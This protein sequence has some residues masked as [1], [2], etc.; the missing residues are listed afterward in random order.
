MGDKWLLSD[1]DCCFADQQNSKIPPMA[2]QIESVQKWKFD[3]FFNFRLQDLDNSFVADLYERLKDMGINVFQPDVMSESGEQIS[4]EIL[5]A[6][7]E[8]RIAITICSK[9]Y[10]SSPRCLEELTKIMECVDNKGLE[11]FFVFYKVEPSDD[12]RPTG[13]F[14]AD[15][16]GSDLEKVQRWQDALRKAADMAGLK[17]YFSGAEL[18]HWNNGKCIE[19]ISN[20]I[21]QVPR[22]AKY[23]VGIKS[24]VEE[25]KSLLKI[26]FGGVYFIGVWGRGGVGKTAV[27]REI[28]DEISCQFE[29]SCFLN[30]R[31]FLENLGPEGP[32]LLQQK[33]LVKILKEHPLN[34]AS[35]NKEVDI[36]QILRFKKVLIVLDDVYNSHQLEYLAGQH[37]WFGDGS[38]IITTT[39]NCDLLSK[40][41]EFYCVPELTNH[42]A[43]ELVS[44]HAF[45]Q[46]TPVKEFQELSCCI[47]DYAKGLPI[48]LEVLGSFLYKQ[49]EERTQC[50]A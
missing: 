34:V 8:S 13:T 22:V 45:Q 39:R 33:L 23:P 28:F 37:E 10:T 29:G 21:C 26:E 5:D 27:V 19:E 43:L 16:K 35:S 24:R 50:I 41:D 44:W 48:V 42:E 1:G 32:A 49:R 2:S 36:S 20:K 3:V 7:E 25:V 11:F 46:G 17:D 40:H 6:I 30:V 4:T 9:D 38:R 18:S 12:L 47:V 15:L 14:D 31:R